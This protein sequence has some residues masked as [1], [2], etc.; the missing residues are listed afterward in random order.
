MMYI[1]LASFYICDNRGEGN[2]LMS[3]VSKLV[4]ISSMKKLNEFSNE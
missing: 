2:E 1:T 3:T 4:M